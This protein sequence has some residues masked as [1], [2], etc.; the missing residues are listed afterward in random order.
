M[1][2]KLQ[3]RSKEI[4]VTDL[5][6]CALK[7][8]LD[9]KEPA[10][11]YPHEMLMK[12]IGIAVHDA[13]D[14][15]DEHVESEIEVKGDGFVGR[16]DAR[17]KNLLEDLKT[18]KKIYMNLVPYG[19]HALQLNVYRMADDNDSNLRINYVDLSGP[20][21]CRSCKVA[22]RYANG[23]LICPRCGWQPKNGHLGSILVDIPR[24]NEEGIEV[25][26]KERVEL[27]QNSLD[28]DTPPEAEPSWLCKY[29]PHSSCPFNGG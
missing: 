3:D 16:M 7:S 5:I 27:L 9:K 29:C 18:T 19:E 23:V 14:A 1:Y 24:M 20:T 26:I 6:G 17:Y 13:V 25:F 2:S 28:T 8:Y 15:N 10:P 11:E 12:F 22:V 21:R 4:H